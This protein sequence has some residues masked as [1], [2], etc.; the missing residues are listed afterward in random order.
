[1]EQRQ[2]GSSDS[3]DPCLWAL[4]VFRRTILVRTCRVQD[5]TTEPSRSCVADH[6]ARFA[7]DSKGAL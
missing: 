3:V 7:L 1:M 6:S 4:T 2:M 5:E